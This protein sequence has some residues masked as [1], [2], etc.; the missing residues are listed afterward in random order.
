M[1]LTLNG[2]LAGLVT[3]T[4]T[5]ALVGPFSSILIGA[6]GGIILGQSLK[7]FERLRLDDA[8]GAVAVH[9]Y[10]G[11]LGVCIAGFLLWGAPSS[12]YEGFATI[13]PLGQFAGAV[14]M[15]GVLGF[16]PGYV[17]SKI[18]NSMGMLR[19]PAKVEI[20]GLDHHTELAYQ[21]AIADVLEAEK[22]I[23]AKHV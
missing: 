13:N 3:S 5:S 1:G 9:G 4:D 7:L 10:A 21:Q 15:F 2:V 17:V 12:P 8:V 22:Q 14:I 18:L 20:E 23:A 11:F 16:L 19:I 6:M